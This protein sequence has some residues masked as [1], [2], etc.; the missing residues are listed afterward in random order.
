[1]ATKLHEIL[2]VERDLE[3]A[4]K[5]I[6]AEAS[7]TFAKKRDR[8]TGGSRVLTMFDEDR[9][10]ENDALTTQMVT[11][12]D[13]KLAHVAKSVGKY[14]DVF[15]TKEASN[16][17]ATADLVVGG[18]T[19]LE[20]L[21]GTLLLGLEKR[22]EGIRKMYDQI[23]TLQPGKSWKVDDTREAGT[24]I[25]EE[26]DT[27]FKTEKTTMHKVLVEPTEHHPANID[28]WTENVNVGRIETMHWS[29]MYTPARKAEVLERLDN[30]IHATK[31][32]R[33]RANSTEATKLKIGEV[34]FKYIN[35]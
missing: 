22:L 27:S 10:F 9:A 26:P 2:A 18:K 13:A 12:V 3:E 7:E 17:T 20:G 24:F 21:P 28:K 33:Q 8:F 4:S 25:T 23:P 34:L 6:T 31:R 14:Y 1:M 32:A 29:G 5:K 11:T 16:Q 30:L 19:L 35:G 15:A